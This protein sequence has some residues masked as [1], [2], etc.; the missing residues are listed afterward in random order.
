MEI[1]DSGTTV[2][3]CHNEIGT[4]A[5]PCFQW[6]AE[7]IDKTFGTVASTGEDAFALIVKEPAGVV[8]LVLPWLFPLLMAAWTLAPALAARCS[9]VL[10]PA[11]ETSLTALYLAE[12]ASEAGGA[13]R[14]I[15]RYS[16]FGRD[17]W[18]GNRS[19]PG[20]LT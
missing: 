8:G 15:K 1:I 3:D 4:E 10:K 11:E 13:S 18:G 12:L 7:L 16:W 5:A 19:S 14:R 17:G 20:L 6:Y 9:L 2:T